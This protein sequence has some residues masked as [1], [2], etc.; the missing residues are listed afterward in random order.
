VNQH[1]LS[2]ARD[3]GLA[4]VT[5][6]VMVNAI[7]VDLKWTVKLLAQAACQ[8]RAGCSPAEGVT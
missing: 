6:Q 8:P 4:E 3:W 5:L 7:T 2:R 1:G